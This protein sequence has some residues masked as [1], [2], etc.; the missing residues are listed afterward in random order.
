MHHLVTS[1]SA[2]R[3][4]GLVGDPRDAPL[5]GGAQ[6]W[7]ARR[8]EHRIEPAPLHHP[9]VREMLECHHDDGVQGG[10]QAL[11]QRG[12]RLLVVRD[13]DEQVLA[14][15]AVALDSGEVAGVFVT[16]AQRR[17]GLGERL[18]KALER[19][20][21]RARCSRLWL[22]ASAHQH[23]A[24]RLFERLDYEVCGASAR[25]DRSAVLLAKGL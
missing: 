18:V 19:D 1:F 6:V 14:C 25:Q 9:Q 2:P 11:W 20:A 21:R 22:R 8:H 3:A 7:V 4:S 24:R 12:A 10:L 15:G 16:P 13:A 23:A 17:H 5:L